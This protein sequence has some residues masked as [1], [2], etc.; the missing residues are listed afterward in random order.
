MQ[1]L[2][3]FLRIICGRQ[4]YYPQYYP[5][6]HP[7]YRY[8]P[9]IPRQTSIFSVRFDVAILFYQPYKFKKGVVIKGVFPLYGTVLVLA[10]ISFGD[11]MD[12]LQS[13]AVLSIE[14]VDS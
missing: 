3:N 8:I 12:L 4:K 13:G 5:Q 10:N 11:Y 14:K 9:T 1:R 2:T 6:Y 7:Q